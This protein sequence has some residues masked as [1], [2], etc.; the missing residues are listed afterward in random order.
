MWKKMPAEHHSKMISLKYH[1][2]YLLIIIIV[3]INVVQANIEQPQLNTLYVQVGTLFPRT[4]YA[5]VIIDLNVEDAIKRGKSTIELTDSFLEHHKKTH[6]K[7]TGQYRS[8]HFISLKRDKIQKNL[9]TLEADLLQAQQQYQVETPQIEETTPDTNTTTRKKR[10]I[11]F[12]I[13]ID[14]NKC[15]KTVVDGVVSLFSSPKSLDK[16]QKSVE[17]VAVRTSRLESK[18]KDLSSKV[19]NILQWIDEDFQNYIGKIYMITS[20]NAALDL[21]D[22]AINEILDSINPLVQGQLTHN[23]LDPLQSQTIIDRTQDEV[24]K[25]NLQVVVDQPVDIL[26]CSITTFATK[27]SW[28]ALISIPLVHREDTMEALQLINIPFFHNSRSLQWDLREGI[29]AQKSGLYPDIE[30]LF[31]SMEDLEDECERF[32]DIFLCH[33][34]INK[35]P[36]CQISLINNATDQCSLKLAAPKVRYSY[37][38]FN[39]LFFQEATK[40]LVEC[41]NER[42]AFNRTGPKYQ[43]SH[44]V[45]HGLVNMERISECTITT[46][47]FRLLP[48]SATKGESTFS[49]KIKSVS[50]TNEELLKATIKFERNQDK[51]QNH[52]EANPWT[53]NK[54]ISD[55][56][57]IKI[58]GDHTIFVHSISMFLTLTLLLSLLAICMMNFLH[59]TPKFLQ[60]RILSF[61]ESLASFNDQKDEPDIA[62][63]EG[64]DFTNNR[65]S[66]I[67]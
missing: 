25:Y 35:F 22:E 43:A 12:D 32:N 60:D 53:H 55:E 1:I 56:E 44:P 37:G 63:N 13:K 61:A 30:N 62:L 59:Y 7:W 23:L 51:T 21:A 65:D 10:S 49:D 26:K 6:Q 8:I 45:Y 3:H 57:D 50:M 2:L 4:D 9:E 31:V 36:T 14:V 54:G 46:D 18:T 67:E 29:I 58:F 20:V 64:Q 16:I 42:Y 17:K 28:F 48:N 34:R 33:H 5:G 47:K 19:D 38:S 27:T 41:P 15:L 39:F 66:L 11:D 24:D 52:Q 40:T